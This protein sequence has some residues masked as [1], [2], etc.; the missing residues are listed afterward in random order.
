MTPTRT[1]A[2]IDSDIAALSQARRDLITGN[3]VSSV[4]HGER[5]VRRNV[6]LKEQLAALDQDLL[7]LR[8]ERARA[9]GLA[10]PRRPVAL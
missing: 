10:S 4:R 1:L 5:E 8:A 2:E 9:L 6:N 7:R 3:A